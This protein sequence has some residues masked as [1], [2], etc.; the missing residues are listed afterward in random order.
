MKKQLNRAN[1][2]RRDT[3]K[4]E[5]LLNIR[6]VFPSDRRSSRSARRFLHRSAFPF[7]DSL[8]PAG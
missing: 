1:T 2:V 8:D 3:V 4:A 5:L 7:G 6:D